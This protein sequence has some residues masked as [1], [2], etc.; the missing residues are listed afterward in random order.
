MKRVRK[1]LIFIE[2]VSVFDD[3]NS[4]TVKFS[5]YVKEG[6]YDLILIPK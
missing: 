5:R 2:N 1:D 6:F 4:K 3:G